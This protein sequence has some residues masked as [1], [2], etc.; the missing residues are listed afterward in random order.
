VVLH[1]L[2]PS[3]ALEGL[4]KSCSHVK[5]TTRV[6]RCSAVFPSLFIVVEFWLTLL[7]LAGRSWRW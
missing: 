5:G 2:Q 4:P 7:V 3:R 6:T 1:P